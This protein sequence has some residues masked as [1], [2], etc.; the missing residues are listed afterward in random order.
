[1]SAGERGIPHLAVTVD[2]NS[3]QSGALEVLRVIRPGWNRDN[4][5]FKVRKFVITLYTIYSE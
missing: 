3:L 1:M 4:I 5:E 2:E